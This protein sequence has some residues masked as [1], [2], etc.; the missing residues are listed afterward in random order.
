[1]TPGRRARLEKVRFHDFQS[2]ERDMRDTFDINV[3][4]DLTDD[5]KAFAILMFHRRHV[6]EHFGGEAD[7]KCINDSGEKVLRP[8]R[9]FFNAADPIGRR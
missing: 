3:A 8:H 7:Q 4:K 1:M 9:H 6:Y 5:E 2:V